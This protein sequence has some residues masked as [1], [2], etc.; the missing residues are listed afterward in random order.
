M[1]T[2]KYT[3]ISKSGEKVSGVVEGFNELDAV[4]RIKQTCDIVLKM[5][6]V[7][8]RKEGLLSMEIGGSKL[9]SKA[10]TVMCS[11]F[12]IIL[13]AGVPIAR[14]VHLIAAKT[15]DKPLKKMLLK[16]AEDVEAGRTIASSF[17]EHGSKL[18]PTTFVET[19]R[20]GEESGNVDKSFDTMYRH[21]DKQTKMKG[22]VKSALAY[23][24]FVLFIAVVVVIVLMVAVVPT[25]T[26]IFESYGSEL[27]LITRIL[28]AIS[29]FFR[30][31]TLWMA[32]AGIILFLIYKIYG[33]TENGRL[34][35]AQISLKIPV[36]GNISQLNA[37]SQFANT[38]TTMLGAGLPMTRAISITAKVL[39]NYYISH[40]I[41]K[42]TG[43]LEEGR[44]L[45]DSMRESGCMPDILVDMVAVGEETGEM[46]ATLDTIALYYD[47][48]LEMAINSA[49]AK[50]EP[51]VLV[52]LA[53]VAGFIVI[54]IYAAM[55]EMYALM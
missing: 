38:M 32:L 42:L 55:F 50:L 30:K 47:A 31:Y 20:A 23:P 39:D 4:D 3:A 28:I 46:E 16:V 1:V 17:A 53:G 33:N 40:E 7:K 36:L 11:Q 51:T 2:Y 44:S 43:R 37:A 52:V 54:A 18:L 45:G 14:T 19:I 12:A 35:F 34:N 5:T 26:S 10:F 24:I 15:T 21:Y 22:K 41:G 8:E 49:L 6:Q 9:N 29:N 13:R 25:F 27:P 48:E